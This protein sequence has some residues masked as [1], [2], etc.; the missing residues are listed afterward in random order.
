MVLVVLL[1][2]S[3]SVWLHIESAEF[4]NSRGSN[5]VAPTVTV[6]PFHTTLLFL[7][8]RKTSESL[9]LHNDIM[10]TCIL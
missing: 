4:A 9:Y 6:D 10:V 2:T 7:C 5:F 3:N 8:P 1:L